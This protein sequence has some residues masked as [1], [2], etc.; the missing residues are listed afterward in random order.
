MLHR[1]VITLSKIIDEI[2]VAV[3]MMGEADI[4][5]AVALYEE[6]RSDI[7]SGLR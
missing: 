3:T 5:K 4:Q 7:L 6:L 1:D 2:T